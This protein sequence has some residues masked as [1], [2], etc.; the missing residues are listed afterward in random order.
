MINIKLN[1]VMNA[2]E[3]F[4]FLQEQLLSARVAYKIG[5][6]TIALE[7]EIQSLQS[8]RFNIIKKYGAKDENGQLIINDNQY[9]IDP[10]NIEAANNELQE[11]M[12][13]EINLNVNKIKLDELEKYD[14]TPI[15]MIALMPFIEE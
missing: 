10:G 9:T 5:K 15:K 1:D 12:D 13:M 14:I 8:A 4:K 11:L 6:I 7:E 3:A 2:V